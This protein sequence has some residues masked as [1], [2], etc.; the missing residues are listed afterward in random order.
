[1]SMCHTRPLGDLTSLFVS[2]C[3]IGRSAN[4]LIGQSQTWRLFHD[5]QAI[6]VAWPVAMACEESQQPGEESDDSTSEQM[7]ARMFLLWEPNWARVS[8]HEPEWANETQFARNES[9][10]NPFLILCELGWD[11]LSQSDPV[12]PGWARGSQRGTEWVRVSQREPEWMQEQTT[13]RSCLTPSEAWKEAKPHETG[14]SFNQNQFGLAG[15]P[16][17]VLLSCEQRET[18]TVLP[19]PAIFQVFSAPTT[20]LSTEVSNVVSKN[21][22]WWTEC[23]LVDS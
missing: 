1:M 18:A 23:S 8:Q 7:W 20:F 22:C 11:T 14:I 10:Q 19:G 6:A 2:W 5:G 3:K 21:S 9:Q 13:S 4:F 17:V 15:R 16:G 12:W